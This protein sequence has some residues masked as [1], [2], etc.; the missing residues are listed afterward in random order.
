MT[1][2]L[3]SGRPS[4]KQSRPEPA[5]APV[6]RLVPKMRAIEAALAACER[7]YLFEDSETGESKRRYCKP[8]DVAVVAYLMSNMDRATGA[9]TR[10][11]E[12]I[13]NGCGMSRS[14]VGRSLKRLQ[15]AKVIERR[16]RFARNRAQIATAFEIGEP[17]TTDIA[18]RNLAPPRPTC[19]TPPSH[20]RDGNGPSPDLLNPVGG[21]ANR[22]QCNKAQA[23]PALD[24]DEAAGWLAQAGRYREQY[25]FGAERCAVDD[26]DQWR[27]EKGDAAMAKAI[28]TAREKCLHGERLID[29]LE[30]TYPRQRGRCVA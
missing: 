27:A 6:V 3:I 30:K 5:A 25:G 9:C 22:R 28:I 15:E 20:Q 21:P 16:A 17:V 13:A 2:T 18:R 4:A 7:G 11:Y 29:F 14:A 8:Q 1:A 26:L 23:P 19:G 24:W 12:T 10:H